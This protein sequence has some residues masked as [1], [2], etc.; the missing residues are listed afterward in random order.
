[1]LEKKNLI[2]LKDKRKNII[3]RLRELEILPI[4]L[5][6]MNENQKKIYDEI[7]NFDFSYWEQVKIDR[8]WVHERKSPDEIAMSNILSQR[9]N[10]ARR[11]LRNHGIFPEYGAEM[12][13]EQTV[14]NE[15][16]DNNDFTYYEKI[17][18]EKEQERKSLIT[19]NAVKRVSTST[20]VYKPDERATLPGY[21]AMS[22]P[23]AVFHRLRMVQILPP[24]GEELNPIQQSIVDDVNENWLGKTK[25][26]YLSKY[27]HLSTPE[28]RLL[29]RL[30]S[31]HLDYGFNFNLTIDDIVIPTHCPYLGIELSTD[32][33]DKDKP[34][35]FTG[36]RIDSSKGLVKG[37][38]QVISMKANKMKNKSTEL[39]L[40]KF[41][42]NGLNLLKD[43]Q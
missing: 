36:D 24:L 12:N 27:L 15:Q 25:R 6:E 33:N 3:N 21:K 39:E 7:W 41:A 26:Y 5:D 1:M 34:N 20:K 29:L 10:T 37:N 22:L 4:P 11:F 14:I 18:S 43:V 42:V 23:K 32:P 8:G 16:I 40:L 9:R 31:T 19:N 30:Y 2:K 28:G 13:E 35:Y 38:L 17:K